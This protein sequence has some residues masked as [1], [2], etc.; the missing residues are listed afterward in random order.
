M[1]GSGGAAPVA[2]GGTGGAPVAAA[3]SGGAGGAGG[4]GGGST[5]IPTGE[6]FALSPT[7]G[8]IAGTTNAVG[9]QGSFFPLSDVADGGST[10]IAP[11]SFEA[12]T[13]PICISGTAS[14]VVGTAYDVYWGGGVGLNLA[15]PGMG[16]GEPGPWNRG[17]V[18]GFRYTLT[19]PTIPPATALRFQ[20]EFPGKDPGTPYCAEVAATNGTPVTTLF[21]QITEACYAAGGA[22]LPAT[23]GL[24]A[25]QWQVATN[26]TAPTPFDFC[27]TDLTAIVQ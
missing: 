6:G 18:V 3:G 9:I 26:T 5:V 17:T 12:V 25:I 13:G 1:A 20:A 22:V 24:T 27:I 8:W 21:S 7:N 10:T 23:V 11:A 4:A 19:G 2:A 15:D 14:Q 16:N